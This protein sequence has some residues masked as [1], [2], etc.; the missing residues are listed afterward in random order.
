MEMSTFKNDSKEVFVEGDG[1]SVTVN[2]W[3]NTEGCNLMVH[4]DSKCLQLRMAGSFRWEEIDAVLVA[5]TAAR[6]S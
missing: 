5:L 6:S 1:V 4:S 3:S 2:T